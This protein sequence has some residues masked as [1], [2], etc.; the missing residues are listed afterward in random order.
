MSARRWMRWVAG[1]AVV[2]AV[3][4]LR[5]GPLPQGLLDEGEDV[6]TLIVDRNGRTLYEA[7]TEAGL[8]LARLGAD[9]LPAQLVNATVAAE[10]R[11]FSYHPGV[12]PL[13]ILRATARNVRRLQVAEGGSTI[14]QQVAKLLLAR[15]HQVA[16]TRRTRGLGAKL[17][18]AIVAIRLEHKFT[19]R[20][21]LALYL[22]LGPYGN[23]IVGAERASLAYFGIPT[24][25]LTAAQAAFLAALPQRPS[26]FN[27]YRDQRAALARQR[28]IL[29][30]MVEL[31][32]LSR[33]EADEALAERLA[34]R[35]DATLFGAPHFVE[36][37][38]A[39]YTGR[40]PIRIETT[41]DADLQDEV[42]GILRSQR[43]TLDR[44]GAHNVAVVV[45]ENATGEWLA[46]EGSGDY[47][48]TDHGGTINGALTLRQ[49]GSALKPLTYA[50]AFEEGRHPA[51]VLPDVPSH[52]PTAEEGVV[53]T[54]RNYDGRF[55]GPLL[56]RRALAGSE[57]V[58]AVVLASEIGVA[59]LVGFFRQA[60]L[61]TFD[62]TASYY[63][64]GVTL[65]N[66]EVKL[67]ELAAAYAALARG[68]VLVLPSAVRAVD[69][70]NGP[71]A[72][73]TD[74]SLAMNRLVS[75]RSAFWV[76]DIMSDP[77][78]REYVFGRGGS[79]EFP[80]PVAVKTG[81]SQAYRDNW[82]L[83]YT[84]EVTVGVWVGNFD[85]TPLT[86]SSGVTGAGPIFHAVML[87][88]Q[89]RATG[90]LLAP[91]DP[92][93][94]V[95]RDV[96][97]RPICTL[98]GM[99][100]NP[101]CP[102]RSNEWMPVE[103]PAL[104]CSWHHQTDEGLLV[105]WPAPYRQWAQEHR[106]LEAEPS[107]VPASISTAGSS[108]DPVSRRPTRVSRDEGLTIVNPPAGAIYLIDPTL[109]QEYQTLAFR[110]SIGR[111][112]GPIEWAVDGHT[113]G[114]ADADQAYLW[115]IVAGRHR[116]V[117]RDARG[118]LAETTILVK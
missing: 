4:W 40:R 104:P 62:Q 78:A 82:T 84:R 102:S 47:F 49:P 25:Q 7:R 23:Q 85:R 70:G 19:K 12:D 77:L 13:S 68:G 33:L 24:E 99:A 88:A 58:P 34:F 76:T 59:R 111:D 31:G 95:P 101:W 61:A 16:A 46:W 113:V 93:A 118:R 96:V 71:E 5:L 106:L 52:F 42:E 83:G 105:V 115:P 3:M 75:A 90:H 74:K 44:H 48:D 80:F 10:D 22:N 100:A 98:S 43:P 69:R 60:G 11:R 50:L 36:M 116:I 18:E 27:P 32:T 94:A 57:N 107:G 17:H 9:Q 64:L 20:D 72:V 109:R 53:Y 2:T 41:L 14:T 37:V 30:Q 55:R 35:S 51:T 15:R 63:G 1:L 54:P 21:I 8:R 110:A 87:A 29:A 66:A 97:R 92:L 6:S 103:D 73:R 114:S 67:A 39:S 26:G 91:V 79:L 86:N 89:Q 117:A 38:L 28:R 56:A 45:L 81:T 65:G 112:G 108:T